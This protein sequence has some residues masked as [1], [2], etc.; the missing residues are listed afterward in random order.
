MPTPHDGRGIGTRRWLPEYTG[1]L[2]AWV[3]PWVLSR[4]ALA[5]PAATHGN[6]FSAPFNVHARGDDF[7]LVTRLVILDGKTV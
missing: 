3:T 5:G 4:T 7:G 1:W 2:F 6:S